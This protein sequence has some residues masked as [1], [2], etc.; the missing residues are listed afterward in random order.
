MK[1][2]DLVH[3]TILIVAILCGYSALRL[4]LE[5]L[6]GLFFITSMY[7][8]STFTFFFA[9]LIQ[10][11]VFL[12]ACIILIRNGRTY[13]AAL[14]RIDSAEKPSGDDAVE[15]QLDRRNILFVLFIGLGL[16]SLIEAIPPVLT[17]AYSLF[18]AKISTDFAKTPARDSIAIDLLRIAIGALLIY[19]APTLT[20]FIDKTIAVR[21]DSGSQSS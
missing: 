20:N 9:S 12:I 5:M 10:A 18:Q 16:Y 19:A 1:K 6:S 2:F 11:A 4:V 15:W 8:P 14:L 21:L 17:Q 3:T 7:G 13:A